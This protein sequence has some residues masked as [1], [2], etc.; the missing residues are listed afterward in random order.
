MGIIV[1]NAYALS[2]AEEER[3]TF[4]VLLWENLVQGYA[5]SAEAAGYPASNL[6]TS[7]TIEGWRGTGSGPHSLTM[8]L[9][10]SRM[11]DGLGL[12]RHNLGS[13]GMTLSLW[14]LAPD[15][16]AEVSGDWSE[17]IPEIIVADD[18]TLMMRFAPESY[19]ALRL[20]IVPVM[21]TPRVAL[22]SVGK[23]LVMERG[24]QAHTPIPWGITRDVQTA[25]SQAG[26]FLARTITGSTRRGS[27]SFIK[28]S[29]GW[30]RSS[31]FLRFA[32]AA[33]GLPFFLSWNP[34]EYPGEVAFVWALNDI[35][36]ETSDLVG[37][38]DV[39]IELEGVVL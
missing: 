31:G 19:A 4:P 39:T 25:R 24:N 6:G 27:I 3:G 8:T 34:E 38:V 11:V 20:D 15:G 30:I 28:L 33:A 16:D 29:G 12:E 14:G 36:P 35:I 17:I 26:D 7:S 13:D 1:A 22:L 23:L 5:A 21:A 9:D 10:P 37:S 2:L 18:G 32:A